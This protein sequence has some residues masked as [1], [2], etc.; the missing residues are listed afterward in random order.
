ME[1][2]ARNSHHFHCLVSNRFAFLLSTATSPL[3][4]RHL[5]ENHKVVRDLRG[6]SF[7]C[8]CL[9]DRLWWGT[10]TIPYHLRLCSLSNVNCSKF[11]SKHILFE[12]HARASILRV[13]TRG[14]RGISMWSDLHTCQS[15]QIRFMRRSADKLEIRGHSS[16]HSITLSCHIG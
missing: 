13:E 12:L 14:I 16:Q 1:E 3:V 15:I 7:A 2:R 5:F 10:F 11:V 9:Q 6:H 4:W 8:A